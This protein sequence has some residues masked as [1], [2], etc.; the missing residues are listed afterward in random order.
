MWEFHESSLNNDQPPLLLCDNDEKDTTITTTADTTTT[1]ATSFTNVDM[2][3]HGDDHKDDKKKIK[4]CS[5]QPIGQCNIKMLTREEISKYFYV[6][7]TEAAKEL[8]V[9]LTI[10]KKRCR[11]LGIRRWPHRKLMSIETLIK[12]V[13]VIETNLLNC[14]CTD[15]L[16]MGIYLKCGLYA[17]L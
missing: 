16:F 11:E 12:N 6:P 17:Y 15:V 10:L 7:I 8:N 3:S 2:D 14:V 13:K 4:S 5:R 9:G 1:V